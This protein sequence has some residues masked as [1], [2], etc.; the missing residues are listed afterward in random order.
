MNIIII[1]LNEHVRFRNHDNNV[2]H[3]VKVVP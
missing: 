2:V 1:E 3:V